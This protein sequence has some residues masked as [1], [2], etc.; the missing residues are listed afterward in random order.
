M[1][2]FIKMSDEM[3]FSACVI[4]CGS[5]GTNSNVD[6]ITYLCPTCEE[7][8]KNPS[9]YNNKYVGGFNGQNNDRTRFKKK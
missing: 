3:S 1:N 2:I 4:T 7:K 5:C 9:K 8:R 6:L